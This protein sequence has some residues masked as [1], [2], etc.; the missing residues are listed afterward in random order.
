MYRTHL[1]VRRYIVPK[2]AE[3]KAPSNHDP[4]EL[5]IHVKSNAF[6][7]VARRLSHVE[8]ESLIHVTMRIAPSYGNGN[9]QRNNRREHQGHD[10]HA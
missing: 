8:D 2:K 4:D 10:D 6:T 5:F 1:K 3:G 7:T 9:Y